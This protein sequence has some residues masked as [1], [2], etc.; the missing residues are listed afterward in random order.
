MNIRVVHEDRDFLVL[1]KPA[2]IAVHGGAG[3]RSETVV[4]WLVRKYPEVKKVGDPSTSSGQ[5]IERPGIVHRLD[6]DTSG[7]LLVARNQKSFE[8]LKHLFKERKVEKTYL[9]LVA[10]APKKKSGVI[11]APIGRSVRQPTKRAIGQR[12][13]GLRAART[14]YR[15]LEAFGGYALLAVKPKTGRMHQIRVHL[16]SLGHPVAGDRIYGGGKVVLKGLGRQFL[17][18]ASLSFSYPEGRRWHF[19][20]SLPDDLAKVLHELRR[21]RK[22]SRYATKTP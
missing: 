15:V 13:A 7:V 17:H 8:A 21:L 1:D 14:A 4:D 16:A 9:A 18:A 11:D 5:A 12:A 2:G 20:A 22:L 19:E 10:G 3:V 6:K